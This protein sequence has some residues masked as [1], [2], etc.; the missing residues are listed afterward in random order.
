MNLIAKLEQE[1]I[2]APV[3][4]VIKAK[5]F[6]DALRIAHA[7]STPVTLLGGGS[8]VLVSDAGVRGRVCRRLL[9]RSRRAPRPA[10]LRQRNHRRMRDE[11][12]TDLNVMFL[13]LGGTLA[14]VDVNEVGVAKIVKPTF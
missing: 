14:V 4:A 6:D 10:R 8:N 3:L 11:V 7:A 1:E 13:M 12:Q 9:L 2:F 5:D